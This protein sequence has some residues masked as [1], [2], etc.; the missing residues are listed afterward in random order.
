MNN[1]KIFQNTLTFGAFDINYKLNFN[2]DVYFTVYLN[3]DHP[4]IKVSTQMLFARGNDKL[5]YVTWTRTAF[6]C[7]LSYLL[8]N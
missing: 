8:S 5:Y 2:K 1:N 4:A 7:Y 6:K 3:K